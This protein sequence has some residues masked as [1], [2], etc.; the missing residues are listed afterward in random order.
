MTEKA[1]Y[2]YELVVAAMFKNESPYL[3]EWVSH[4]LEHGASHIVL[5]DNGSTDN[6]R[7][8]VQPW[9]DSGEVTLFDWP[10]LKTEGAQYN[11]IHHSLGLMRQRARWITFLDLDEFLF[12]PLGLPLPDVLSEFSGE[13]GIDV[14]WV[15]YGSS[16]HISTPSGSVRDNF[17]RRA[18]LQFKRNRQFKTII[19]PREAVKRIP[20]SHEWSFQGGKAAVNEL[21]RR[22][23]VPVS[24]SDRIEQKIRMVFPRVHRWLA[25]HFP[26]SFS[27]FHLIVRDVSV[28]K[29]RINHY[30]VKSREEYMEKQVR[31][32][33]SREDKYSKSFFTY[34]DRNEVLDPI[35]SSSP[36]QVDQR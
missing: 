9:I 13:V 34:H 14:H 26:I 6:G 7:A 22:L 15:C 23:N 11:A 29:L 1:T 19:N 31:H 5:Y 25:V 8:E 33:V 17:I 30:I 16:G 24:F 36:K 20:G 4:H 3:A 21:R 2:Q 27:Y 10:E 28:E 12:S 32:G 35:L 18:P